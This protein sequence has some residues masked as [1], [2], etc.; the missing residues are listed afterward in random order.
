MTGS[1]V[2]VKEKTDG[3]SE[4]EDQQGQ[5]AQPPRRELASGAT[6]P[7]RLPPVRDL[8]AAPR[9]LPELRLVQGSCRGRGQL[10]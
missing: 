9:R 3:S 1:P 8:E 4:E 5:D 10:S 2:L 6:G 7:Q